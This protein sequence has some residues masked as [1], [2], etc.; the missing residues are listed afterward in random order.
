MIASIVIAVS[1]G[2]SVRL[3]KM[4]T[5]TVTLRASRM[6]AT[7]HLLLDFRGPANRFLGIPNRQAV[8]E[9]IVLP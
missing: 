2:R 3:A 9:T 5:R 7:K 8:R 6:Q 1:A 4:D